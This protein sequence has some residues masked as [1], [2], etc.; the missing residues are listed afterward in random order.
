MMDGMDRAARM[1]RLMSILRGVDEILCGVNLLQ[2]GEESA[3]NL[4]C[5]HPVHFQRIYR[6]NLFAP[7]TIKLSCCQTLSITVHQMTQ[8]TA[9][10]LGAHRGIC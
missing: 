4:S 3:E 9:S 2:L 1:A 10:K 5:C 7:V 6:Q 8:R